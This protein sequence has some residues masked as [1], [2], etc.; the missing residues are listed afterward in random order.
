M[1]ESLTN[2]DVILGD[3]CQRSPW[4]FHGLFA[5]AGGML[6][7]AV[8]L[9]SPVAWRNRQLTVRLTK[10]VVTDVKRRAFGWIVA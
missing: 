6:A 2:Q 3:P 4:E 9:P 7:T 1:G 8:S 5:P 10:V